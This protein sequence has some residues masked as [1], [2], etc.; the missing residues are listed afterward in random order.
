MLRR[1]QAL[2]KF[3]MARIKGTLRRLLEAALGARGLARNSWLQIAQKLGI[4]L[5]RIAGGAQVAK[6]HP[7]TGASYQPG[8]GIKVEGPGQLYYEIRN[9]YPFEK[10]K[11]PGEE[12]LSRSIQGELGYFEKNLKHGVFQDLAAIAKKYKGLVTP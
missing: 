12:I 2:D 9:S 6:A 3:R 4:T 1:F 11:I 8:S 5:N 10:F 7:S